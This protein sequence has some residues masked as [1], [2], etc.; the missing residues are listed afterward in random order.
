MA[1]LRLCRWPVGFKP[2]IQDQWM[3]RRVHRSRWERRQESSRTRL[4]RPWPR[5]PIRERGVEVGPRQPS[6]RTNRQRAPDAFPRR[7]SC[8]R[9][10]SV[11]APDRASGSKEQRSI[12]SVIRSPCAADAF[13]SSSL[14][15]VA[16]RRNTSVDSTRVS[17]GAT[18]GVCSRPRRHGRDQDHGHVRPSEPRSAKLW[19]RATA[20]ATKDA[21]GVARGEGHD[22]CAVRHVRQL[23]GTVAPPTAQGAGAL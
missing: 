10:A 7:G 9:R 1:S 3:A 11:R 8:S 23:T 16:R 12:G 15:D 6:A 22:V 21:V 13:S 4:I 14:P 19:S 5:R 20:M 18:T 17:G 2:R